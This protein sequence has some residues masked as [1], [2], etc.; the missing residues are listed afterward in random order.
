MRYLS[1]QL[2][3]E[4]LSNYIYNNPHSLSR[5]IWLLWQPKRWIKGRLDRIPICF[6]VFDGSIKDDDSVRGVILLI[7]DCW[8]RGIQFHGFSLGLSC[9]TGPHTIDKRAG[10]GGNSASFWLWMLQVVPAGDGFGANLCLLPGFHN[11]ALWH[12]S[13]GGISVS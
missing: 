5:C 7:C 4:W 8:E 13:Q 10:V 11:S 6:Q 12:M 2:Q 1:Q 9:F 3:L